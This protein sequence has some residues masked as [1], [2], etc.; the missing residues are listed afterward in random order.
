MDSDLSKK[1]KGEPEVESKLQTRMHA[2]AATTHSVGD[3]RCS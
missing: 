1:E 2:F 3:N